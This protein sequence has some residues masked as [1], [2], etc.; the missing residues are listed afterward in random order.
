MKLFKPAIFFLI[1][2]C[3]FP[4]SLEASSEMAFGY[5]TNITSNKDF[6][7]LEIVFPSSF[8]NSIKNIYEVDV[9]KPYEVDERL[10]EYNLK[11]KKKYKLY[12]LPEIVE[13]IDADFFIFGSF[14]PLP[15]NR[16]KIVLNFYRYGSNNIFTFTN[17]SKMETEVVRLVDRITKILIDFIDRERL[18]K[19]QVIPGGS[20]LAFLTNL[21]GEEL[22]LLYYTFMKQGYKI[23]SLQ[24]SSIYNVLTDD[25]INKFKFIITENNSYDTITDRRKIKFRY[26]S[27]AGEKYNEEITYLKKIYRIYDLNYSGLKENI[28]H[29]LAIS[30][31]ESID[32]LLIT[33]FEDNR[34]S[35][36]VRCIN[37]KYRDL[38]WMQSNIEGSDIQEICEKMINSMTTK[39]KDSLQIKGELNQ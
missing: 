20:R 6:K 28:L 35:T 31:D 29:R 23:S 3:L 24:G 26:G 30:F 39:L 11:L 9:V 5:L 25:S 16:I 8:A 17:I 19:T 38:V 22:N 1:L 27:W 32:Y 37:L 10:K 12:E 36:W 13:K 4:I 21:G 18:Y 33:G 34:K 15:E 14:V 2:Q 7:Y